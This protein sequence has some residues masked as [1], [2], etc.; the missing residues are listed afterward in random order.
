MRI[1]LVSDLHYAL[2]QLDWV[3]RSAPSFDL[4]VLAGDHLDVS[5]PVSLDAQSVVLL[6]YFSLM[7][8]ATSLVVASGNHDLTGPDQHG[9]R[10]ALWLAECR[11][12]GVSTDSES[13]AIG[14][15]LITIC[16]WWDGPAGRAALELQLA[17]DAARRPARWVWI[18][19]WP[20]LGSPTCWTGKREYGDADLAAWIA[21]YQP[22]LV[23]CGHVHEPPFKP[24]GAWADRMGATWVFNAGKQIGPVPAHI[25]IDLA[26]GTASWHSMMG[27]EALALEAESAPLRSV[28]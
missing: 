16:P 26:A 1:L 22:E 17:A 20:P 10:A 8:P 4:V 2:P 27:E 19:H 5:S 15:T 3:V 9:E 11:R 23:L 14:D 6:R 28:F 7:R 12:A 13:L 24:A 25:V 21:K 18:Y